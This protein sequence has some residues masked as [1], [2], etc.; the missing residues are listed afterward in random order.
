MPN[1]EVRKALHQSLRKVFS[2]LPRCPRFA[3]Y[4]SFVDCDPKP[5]PRLV[6]KIA[7]T[8]E[9]LEVVELSEYGFQVLSPAPLPINTWGKTRIQL[10]KLEKSTVRVMAVRNKANGFSDFHAF[11]M[12]EPDLPWRKFVNALQS[13]TTH[14][15]LEN[16]TRFIPP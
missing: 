14:E 10:S 15:D 4:R 6:L 7:E 16:A 3:I 11:T 1:S 13:G 8:R 12:G 5:D 9:E 2:F